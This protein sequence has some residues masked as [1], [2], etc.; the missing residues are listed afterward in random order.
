MFSAKLGKLLVGFWGVRELLLLQ[1]P[2]SEA[3]GFFLHS[4]T[5]HLQKFRPGRSLLVCRSGN[6]PKACYL[7][8][9]Q[10]CV[11]YA[12][13]VSS[14]SSCFRKS[15]PCLQ[16]AAQTVSMTHHDPCHYVVSQLCSR[17]KSGNFG[18]DTRHQ[19]LA[20]AKMS[21]VE[22]HGRKGLTKT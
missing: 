13:S 20:R 18:R 19:V 4:N 14:C 15:E 10:S 8:N 17:Q 1:H 9:I 6:L 7:I 2:I 21:G 16:G 3:Y 11:S 5:V 22:C 12:V